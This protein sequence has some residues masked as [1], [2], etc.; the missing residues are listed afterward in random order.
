MSILLL[1]LGLAVTFN[2][3]RQSLTEIWRQSPKLEGLRGVKQKDFPKCLSCKARDYCYMCLVRNYNENGGDLYKISPH[4]CDTIF[5]TK[6]IM[7]DRIVLENY[8]KKE[9]DSLWEDYKGLP[10]TENGY[11]IVDHLYKDTVLFVGLNPAIDRVSVLGKRT[12]GDLKPD[13]YSYFRTI[14]N[15][16]NSVGIS[17][18]SYLDLLGIR[19]NSQAIIRG[20]VHKDS[21]YKGFCEQQV[22]IAVRAMRMAKPRVIVV[23]NAFA[24]DLLNEHDGFKT[25]F[26]DQIGTDVIV[27]RNELERTP[28][29]FTSMLSGRHSLDVGSRER[30]IWHI[31][32]VLLYVERLVE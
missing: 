15:I 5:L 12:F 3:F 11:D 23:C 29:F 30:L 6:K 22:D 14:T 26:D 18:Y 7:E 10:L 8:F 13:A 17:L 9:Y 21:K 20:N 31:K 4:F 25:V 27:S 2:V 19:N 16:A 28:V 32:Q 24:R 1:L